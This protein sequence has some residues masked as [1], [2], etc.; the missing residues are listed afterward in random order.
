MTSFDLACREDRESLV[1]RFFAGT[2]RSYD[3][4]VLTTTLGLD[5]YWKRRL[6]GHVPPRARSILDLGCGTGI[7]TMR[8]H[9]RAPRARIVGVDLTPEYLELARVR[10]ADV[11]A[12][13]TFV[14]ANVETMALDR[15]FDAVVSSYV[16]KYADPH[17][18]LDR[19]DDRVRPGGIV[20]LHDFDYPREPLAYWCWQGHMALVRRLG[21]R[22]F[23]AWQE[24][25]EGDLA[26]L[27]QA[28]P[29]VERYRKALAARGYERIRHE[30]LSFRTAS[31]VS[32]RKPT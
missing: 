14:H 3:R 27:I 22:L 30:R 17:V 9:R 16:P 2:A 26:S 19:L 7:V 31:I 25:F 10:F 29:W 21:L 23:P 24:A 32:A 1:R 18:L 6:V 15:T 8:L 5:A 4:V 28:S 20:A 11:P 13:V 12:D